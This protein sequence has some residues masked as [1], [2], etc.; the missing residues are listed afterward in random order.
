M[1]G[2]G[3]PVGV[4]RLDVVRIGLAAPADE[5]ALGDRGGLVDLGLR[6]GRP[7]GAARGLRDEGERHHRRPREVVAGLL[8]GDV[9]EG[10]EP[11][12]GAEHR[13]RGLHAKATTPSS[14]D[15]TSSIMRAGRFADRARGR[16][17]LA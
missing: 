11:P 14:P 15:W 5:E 2:R 10:L 3:D 4:D 17:W 12:L 13:Q 8:V 6:H 7:A 1:L 9:D 16:T